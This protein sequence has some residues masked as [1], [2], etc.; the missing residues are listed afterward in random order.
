MLKRGDWRAA[1][2]NSSKWSSSSKLDCPFEKVP[3]T[4]LSRQIRLC[5]HFLRVDFFFSPR[6]IS[7]SC[8]CVCVRCWI[9]DIIYFEN[10]LFVYSIAINMSWAN[11]RKTVRHT[12]D[13]ATNRFLTLTLYC[14]VHSSTVFC[15]LFYK[16][17]EKSQSIFV[18][19]SHC[20]TRF[21]LLFYS[22]TKE[23]QKR[24]KWRNS[25][26]RIPKSRVSKPNTVQFCIQS[27]K[28]IKYKRIGGCARAQLKLR[29]CKLCFFPISMNK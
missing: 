15:L 7:F 4:G 19:N 28:I 1:T 10:F 6:S 9:Y 3:S 22:H 13:I 5:A 2:N 17:A 27:E 16:R 20:R 23:N 18:F 11:A 14:T 29:H 21:C 24:K 26:I 25:F 8:V 12:Y